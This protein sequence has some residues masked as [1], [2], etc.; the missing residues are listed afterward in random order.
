MFPFLL[1]RNGRDLEDPQRAEEVFSWCSA[2]VNWWHW[3]ALDG[4]GIVNVA[5]NMFWIVLNCF[6]IYI[7]PS[8]E[9]P[10]ISM[11]QLPLAGEA[12]HR[13]ARRT[14]E[15]RRTWYPSPFHN[16][17]GLPIEWQDVMV[18]LYK[19]VCLCIFQIW[20]DSGLGGWNCIEIL[21]ASR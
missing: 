9:S 1:L 14:S 21:L 19:V 7:L 4:I 5:I 3:N 13:H 16:S 10:C 18:L 15:H 17:W 20:R 11:C 6:N 2:F 12:G 8:H